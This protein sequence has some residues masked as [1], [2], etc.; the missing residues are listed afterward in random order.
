MTKIFEGIVVSKKVQKTVVVVVERQKTHPLY[1][2]VMKLSK[3]YHVHDEL[4][5]KEGDK[6]SFTETRPISK[7]KRWKVV[8]RLGLSK[9]E[10]I[11]IEKGKPANKT[12][13]EKK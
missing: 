6:V 2:K 11:K 3:K 1:G 7:T 4:G 9:G 5:V 8:R 10:E 12:G 13:K